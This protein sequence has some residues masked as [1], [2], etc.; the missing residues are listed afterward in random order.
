LFNCDTISGA[1]NNTVQN[2][3]FGKPTGGGNW[4]F[5]QGYNDASP[6]GVIGS[7]NVVTNCDIIR[8]N[9]EVALVTENYGEPYGIANMV[10]Q[11]IRVQPTPGNDFVGLVHLQATNQIGGKNLTFQYI[12]LPAAGHSFV[13]AGNW[14]LVFDHVYVN[15]VVATQDSDLNLT[16]GAGVTTTYLYDGFVMPTIS[17]SADETNAYGTSLSSGHYMLKANWL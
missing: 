13:A 11:N 15:G 12:Y 2:C 6:G 1:Y 5:P 10:F 7:H 3:T 4:C 14:N 8:M 17:L 16:K 9:G